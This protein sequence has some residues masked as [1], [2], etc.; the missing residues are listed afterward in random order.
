MIP[1]FSTFSEYKKFVYNVSN[2]F[3]KKWYEDFY[4]VFFLSGPVEVA[5]RMLS[6]VI[7]L[8]VNGLFYLHKSLL[9]WDK[10]FTANLSN[11]C[12]FVLDFFSYKF[13]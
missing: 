10:L 9:T 11:Y 12:L 7:R 5:F 2:F 8:S 3:V 6:F 1:T 4:V 13:S